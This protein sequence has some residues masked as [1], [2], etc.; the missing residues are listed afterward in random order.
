MSD[1][2]SADPVGDLRALVQRQTQAAEAALVRLGDLLVEIEASAAVPRIRLARQ[3]FAQER[4]RLADLR[5]LVGHDLL[6]LETAAPADRSWACAA[7]GQLADL[8]ERPLTSFCEGLL[9]GVMPMVGAERGYVLFWHE[10][11][12]EA[13]LI[14]ARNFESRNL[15][16]GEFRPSRYI[17]HAALSTGEPVR[18]ADTRQSD[19]ATARS[20]ALRDRTAVLVMPLRHGQQTVGALYFERA[21]GCSFEDH[22]EALVGAAGRL[23]LAL[24]RQA[25]L[26]PQAKPTL[27]HFL[28]TDTA[29][30]GIV[31]SD[32]RL[33]EALDLVR[34][35]APSDALVLIRGETGVGKDLVARALHA[36]SGRRDTPL[37]TI[38]CAAIP[39]GLVESELFGHERGAF[40]GAT[41]RYEGRIAQASG[42]TLFLDEVGELPQATQSKLLRFLQFGEISRLGGRGVSRVETRVV[43]ATSRDLQRL[44]ADGQFSAALY[45]RLHVVAIDLP[46][47]RERPGDIEPLF[48]HFLD[49][50]SR[51][52]GRELEAEAGLLRWLEGYAFPGNVRELENIVHR[53]VVTTIEGML[54]LADL[55]R[56]LRGD[57]PTM[58]SLG[59]GGEARSLADL[60][61]RRRSQAESY[62]RERRRLCQ[63]AVE[64]YGGS[65]TRAA[66]SLGIH[67]VTLHRILGSDRQ[68]EDL[69]H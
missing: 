27:P 62:A 25:R 45:Y 48:R 41:E 20:V 29:A 35:I 5:Q 7:L 42:G 18:L 6:P 13:E 44:V 63:A 58:F 12:D 34:R 65:V 33:L 56:D 53:L 66:A 67:R 30:R 59:L 40:T 69:A 22:H 4:Q 43:A 8:V 17:V 51:R 64:A 37:V 14:A 36:A 19:F 1:P 39:E 28:G 54:G 21:D 32:P 9:D 38:N 2:S 61:R 10:P 55:P 24:L 60:D 3:A 68:P 16:L 50:Y 23:A 49:K 57:E 11:S 26:L 52:Y 31:G 46:P 47:L 15:S